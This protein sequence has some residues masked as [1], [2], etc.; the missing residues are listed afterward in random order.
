M[1][2]S[3]KNNPNAEAFRRSMLPFYLLKDDSGWKHPRYIE[4]SNL[5]K[6]LSEN[7]SI[8][9]TI[10]LSGEISEGIES[11]IKY[12]SKDDNNRGKGGLLRK[13]TKI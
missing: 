4:M 8:S 9:I 2:W 11:V 7:T 5:S 13:P 6:N 12:I 1:K 10:Y 3:F